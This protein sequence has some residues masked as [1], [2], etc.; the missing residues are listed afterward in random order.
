MKIILLI[1]T[2]ILL[3]GCSIGKDQEKEY[4]VTMEQ[5]QTE[6]KYITSVPLLSENKGTGI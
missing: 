2:L 5:V 4:M 3:N 1:L 6:V